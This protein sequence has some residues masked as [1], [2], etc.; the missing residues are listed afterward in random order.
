MA[1]CLTDEIPAGVYLWSGH[2]PAGCW[3]WQEAEDRVFATSASHHDLCA[4]GQYTHNL[5]MSSA[6]K[7][8]LEDAL[9]VFAG[10]T[11]VREQDI[12]TIPVLASRPRYVVYGPP[13]RSSRRPGIAGVRH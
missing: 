3:F 10:L 7:T 6:A 5:D 11:Y 8:D 1:V 9:K 12:A 4:I 13:V 2:S